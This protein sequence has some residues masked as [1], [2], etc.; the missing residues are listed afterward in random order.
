MISR[1]VSPG[2]LQGVADGNWALGVQL[3]GDGEVIDAQSVK[4][5]D[6]AES[7]PSLHDVGS[8]RGS[9]S[10]LA[11]DRGGAA[12]EKRKNDESGRRD[13]ESCR[14]FS[15]RNHDVRVLLSQTAL[16]FETHWSRKRFTEKI[17]VGDGRCVGPG[18]G[19][20]LDLFRRL[21]RLLRRHGL[22]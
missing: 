16:H 2:N 6:L 19:T 14:L 11:M 21:A 13:R 5:G 9:A 8:I 4:H 18:V 10:V 20:G 15:P 7:L 1:P 12:Q 22:P 17:S 3:V